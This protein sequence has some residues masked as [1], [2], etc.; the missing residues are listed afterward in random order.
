MSSPARVWSGSVDGVLVRPGSYW[1]PD[2]DAVFGR[3]GPSRSTTIW[4]Y[5]R[6]EAVPKSR[7]ALV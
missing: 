5:E 6:G 2:N 1:A 4:C 7:V 3:P